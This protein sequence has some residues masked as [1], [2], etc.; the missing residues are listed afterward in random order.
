MACLSREKEQTFIIE[1]LLH[2]GFDTLWY[3]WNL[4]SSSFS[5][6][7][8]I[9]EVA[10]CTLWNWTA[11]LTFW[12]CK[13]QSLFSKFLL[14]VMLR[15]PFGSWFQSPV[16]SLSQWW[17]FDHFTAQFPVLDH[18]IHLQVGSTRFQLIWDSPLRWCTL[19]AP[20]FPGFCQVTTPVLLLGGGNG[21]WDF[22]ISPTPSFF[23]V[24]L[25]PYFLLAVL[26][27]IPS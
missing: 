14:S 13:H 26:D 17:A 12:T 18:F 5:N 3:M 16:I 6:W 23:C 21:P 7:E 10:F 2:A 1:D 8:H 9:N 4:N 15:G 25:W 19:S 20:A 24:T 27:Y 11:F 22:L